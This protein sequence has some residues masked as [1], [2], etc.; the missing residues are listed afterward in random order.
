MENLWEI[1]VREIDANNKQFH[2]TDEL[3]AAILNTWS[4]TDAKTTNDLE[5]RM[6]I[7]IFQLIQRNGNVIDY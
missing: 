5:H 6:N 2:S 4:K 1:L 3:K 7:H